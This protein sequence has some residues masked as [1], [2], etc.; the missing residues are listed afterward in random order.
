VSQLKPVVLEDGPAAG[1]PVRYWTPLP[2]IL[3]VATRNGRVAWHDYR[4]VAPGR[5]RYAPPG[6]T[7]R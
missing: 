2:K 5:Y 3:V 4:R 1:Q 6:D 7:P